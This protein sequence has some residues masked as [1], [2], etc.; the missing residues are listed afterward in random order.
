[1][2]GNLCGRRGTASRLKDGVGEYS[3]LLEGYPS[4]GY[5][6]FILPKPA[7]ADRADLILKMLER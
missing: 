5:E 7:V 3:R 2:A 1:L 6:V 4:L